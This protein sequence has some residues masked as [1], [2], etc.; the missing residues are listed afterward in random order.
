VSDNFEE[1]TEK[2]K[3][4]VREYL[5]DLNAT[6]AAIRAGYSE[7][8][9][10]QIGSE[11]LS[12]PDIQEAIQAAISERS[13]RTQITQDRVIFELARVAFSNMKQFATWGP[14]GVELNHSDGLSDGDGACVAEVSESV[15]EY[16]GS[17]K[18]K[19]YDKIKALELLGK[20]LGM[21]K[22]SDSSAVN[23]NQS[24]VSMATDQLLD[25]I[26]KAREGK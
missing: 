13:V 1:L 8:S 21:F 18:F 20:H 9:A 3:A 7:N 24:Q 6:R 14:S 11:T 10:R 17:R 19:L 15:S 23:I 5:V 16:G 2:E 4:F 22:E 26:R 25:L 12:K